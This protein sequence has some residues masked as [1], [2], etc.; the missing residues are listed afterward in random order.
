MSNLQQSSLS[1]QTR[2]ISAAHLPPCSSTAGA[3]ELPFLPKAH[4]SVTAAHRKPGVVGTP[5]AGSG[6]CA[7][8]SISRADT[9]APAGRVPDARGISSRALA[10]LGRAHGKKGMRRQ[11]MS[12][13]ISREHE[14]RKHSWTALQTAATGSRH[15]CWTTQSNR[16]EWLSALWVEGQLKVAG[17]L[18]VTSSPAKSVPRAGPNTNVG[19]NKLEGTIP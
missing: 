2:C 11:T 16:C 5:P 6:M 14:L 18:S 8:S 4:V 3:H 17:K 10:D 15:G 12:R 19:M 1:C 13:Q 7:R 9:R